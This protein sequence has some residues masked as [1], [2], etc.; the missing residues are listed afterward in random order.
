MP[1]FTINL[2][3][4]ASLHPDGDPS[5]FISEYC[6]EV[7]SVADTTGETIV[8]Y[9]RAYKLHVGLAVDRGMPLFD[10]CDC[11]SQ[12]MHSIHS[13]LYQPDSY[14]VR[15]TLAARFEAYESDLLVLDYILLDPKWRG[16]K[17]GLLA[18][19]K[20]VDLLGG[21]C[22]LVVSE[23][24]PLRREAH[25]DL[26][27]PEEWI[28]EATTPG[29]LRRYFRQMGFERLGKTPY[30]AMPTAL[31]TPTAEELLKPQS[32]VG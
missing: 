17:I 11:Y 1:T 15:D 3:T 31:V 32:P 27:V 12:G 23:I 24:S 14:S 22:G 18:A 10:V 20:L 5:E 13:L 26:D 8:G 7:L 9:L 16:L 19:R 29:S 4:R 21:G 2:T 30:Y 25:N 28:P 6:G